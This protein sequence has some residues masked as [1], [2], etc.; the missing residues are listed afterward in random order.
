MAQPKFIFGG[1]LRGLFA[2]GI[3]AILTVMLMVRGVS[4]FTAGLPVVAQA[5]WERATKRI[6]LQLFSFVIVR[7]KF[8]AKPLAFWGMIGTLVLS[9]AVLGLVLDRWQWVRRRSVAAALAAFM[10]FFFPLAGLATVSATNLLAARFEADGLTVAPSAV[11]WQVILAIAAYAAVFALVYALLELAGRPGPERQK[12]SRTSSEGITRRD[13]LHRTI[14]LAIGSLGGLG[15]ARWLATAGQKTVARAQTLFDRIKGL[16][17]EITPTSDF[18]VVSKNPPGFD[19]VVNAQRWRLEIAGHVGRATSLA[20]DEL[21]VFPSV[22]RPHTLECISNDVGGDLISSAMWRG[23]PL[24]DVLNKAGGVGAKAIQIAFRCADGYTESLPVAEALNPDTL[25]VYEMN[26]APLPAKHGYPVRLLVPGHFGMKNPKWITK[27][28]AVDYDFL[29][30]WERSGWSQQAIVKTMSKFT[31][32]LSG[33]MMYKAGE[34]VG[35]GGVAYAGDR[36]IQAVEVSTDDGKTWQS[37][38][39][40]PPLGKYT[41]VLWAAVWTPTVPGEYTVRVRA[42]DGTGTLQVRE[43][44]GTLPDGASGYHRIRIRVSK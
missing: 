16:P 2:G 32:P 18:Y 36:G 40:K 24:R 21:K 15:L 41:W 22:Q 9:A 43:E 31:T 20:Y 14:V 42:R 44:V 28:E 11:V 8:A 6:P 5:L 1:T 34:K 12:V 4:F 25:L 7:F 26:G 38:Q 29:G 10:S 39:V 30:Y 19:P 37:A 3:A 17:P 23:V 35:L 33:H 13:V 27:I